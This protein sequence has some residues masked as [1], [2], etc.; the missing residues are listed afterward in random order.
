MRYLVLVVCG[1]RVCVVISVDYTGI[2]SV[3]GELLGREREVSVE[4]DSK[5]RITPYCCEYFGKR[6]RK[7][8][9]NYLFCRE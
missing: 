4:T 7:R 5:A 8:S 9:S 6:E 3:K 1:E 2:L